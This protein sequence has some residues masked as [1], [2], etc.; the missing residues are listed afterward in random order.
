ME[1]QYDVIECRESG[2]YSILL[3]STPVEKV[4]FGDIF[5]FTGNYAECE[6][7]VYKQLKKRTKRV[8]QQVG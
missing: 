7:Y 1:N 5:K 8:W 3:V 2:E 6:R 4:A